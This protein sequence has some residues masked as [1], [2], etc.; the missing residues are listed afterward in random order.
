[1]ANSRQY[2]ISLRYSIV[3]ENATFIE[4]QII[5]LL[6]TVFSRELCM[7]CSPSVSI[8]TFVSAVVQD[9]R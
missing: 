2:K 9:Q 8:M 6:I 4:C 5:H 7:Y 3:N 1:M